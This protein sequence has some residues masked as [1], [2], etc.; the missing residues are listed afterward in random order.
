[1]YRH[2][3]YLLAYSLLLTLGVNYSANAASSTSV[4]ITG[5]VVAATCEINSQGLTG[6][7]IDLG[8]WGPTSFVDAHTKVGTKSF[9]VG[10]SNCTGGT[11]KGKSYYI[12]VNGNPMAGHPE[13][14]AD[15]GTETVGIELEHN[16]L[17]V[18]NGDAIQLSASDPVKASGQAI[19]FNASMVSP[20]ASGNVH[21]SAQDVQ[22]TIVFNADYK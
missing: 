13:L 4:E 19:V 9:S 15:L 21:P 16:Q 11:E 18:K 20:I 2:K 5:R 10:L 3:K 7:K 17:P 6:N 1:M 12:D 14:F 22:A 8:A